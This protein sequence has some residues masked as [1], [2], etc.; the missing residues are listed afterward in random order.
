MD[1]SRYWESVADSLGSFD[2]RHKRIFVD[3]NAV[4][5]KCLRLQ[6]D[7]RGMQPRRRDDFFVEESLRLEEKWYSIC[8]DQEDKTEA[9]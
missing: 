2:A 5:K 8:A 3:M 6:A 4:S 7:I 1:S 9:E